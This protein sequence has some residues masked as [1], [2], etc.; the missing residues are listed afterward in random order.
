[1]K[2]PLALCLVVAI[3]FA[4]IAPI[5]A[6]EKQ[7]DSFP[8]KFYQAVAKGKVDSN[9][10]ISPLS[11]STALG[12]AY[13]GAEG[14]TK[15]ALADVLDFGDASDDAVNQQA[16]KDLDSLRN[17]GGGTKLEIANALFSEKRFKFN[18][19]FLSTDREFYDAEVRPLD[20]KSP[21]AVPAINSWVSEKTHGKIP[22]IID[23]IGADAVLF[24]I[25]AIYFK[26]I[27][28][29]KFE[30]DATEQADFCTASGGTKKV[31]MMH[32][33][34][35]DFRYMENDRFQAV[36]LSYADKRLSMYVFLPKQESS[37]ALFEAGLNQASWD[38][39][40]S[41]F[42]KR[43]G[44][45][46]LPR[47]KIEDKYLLNDPLSDIG[48]GIAFD[49]ARADFSRMADLTP[50]ERLY[51]SRVLHKTFMDVNEEGTEAAAVTA[52]EFSVTSAPMSPVPPFRMIVDRPFF[53]AVC[54]SETG[55][56]LFAGHI[57][58]P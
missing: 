44:F 28:E 20:F 8:F 4:G 45:I 13:P 46:G 55:K 43:E 9:L 37:L 27:W 38:E 48:L 52:I 50:A 54:D 16:K 47:F 26:G 33:S 11:V 36:N 3:L 14:Q 31:P 41:G 1:M 57:V 23:E 42:G 18:D 51:F 58:N 21:E 53:I 35:S 49:P 5:S 12:M 6:K 17:P 22:T 32:M 40:L 2:L 29:H 10:L 34:R 7:D 39:W 24:L 19:E 25:N 30:K 15:K 56:I